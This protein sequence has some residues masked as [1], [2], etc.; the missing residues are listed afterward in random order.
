M[1]RLSDKTL[2]RW[3]RTGRPT[4]VER[5]LDDPDVTARLEL[6]TR[7]D[8][9]EV[10]ALRSLSEPGDGFEERVTAGASRRANNETAGLLIDLLGL[11]WHTTAAIAEPP[12]SDDTPA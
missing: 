7:L 6:L 3:L 10:A 4:R 12:G 5:H 1:T 2:R 8:A 11:G 9:G